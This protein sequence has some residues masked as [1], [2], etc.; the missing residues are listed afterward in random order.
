MIHTLTLHEITLSVYLGVS[1]E[2]QRDHQHITLDLILHFQPPPV[3]CQTDQLTDTYCY[4]TLI[5]QLQA[6]CE[7]KRFHLIESLTQYLFHTIKCAYPNCA[8]DLSLTKNP[9]IDE[10]AACTYRISDHHD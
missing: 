5:S 7:N 2:E 3:A 1:E 10:V 6:S 4:Q 8:I 9:P